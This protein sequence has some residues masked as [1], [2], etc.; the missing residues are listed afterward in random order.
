[1]TPGARWRI[2]A[3]LGGLA[4]GLTGCGNPNDPGQRAL[5]GGL[6]GAGAG[7]AVG[8]IVGGGP[9]AATGAIIGGGLGAVGGA[10][11]APS[12]APTYYDPPP[13]RPYRGY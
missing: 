6:V 9:G 2:G 8:S 11:T 10:A 4:L 1:M 13:R 3:V 7:A 12:P 5:A